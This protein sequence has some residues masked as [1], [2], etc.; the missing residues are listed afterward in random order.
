M[1]PFYC[2]TRVFIELCVPEVLSTPHDVQFNH[3]FE[4]SR[5]LLSL[6][7]KILNRASAVEEGQVHISKNLVITLL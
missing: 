1:A 3:G 5:R 7:S 4:E 6:V 2:S